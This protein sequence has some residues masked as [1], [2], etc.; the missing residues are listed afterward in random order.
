MDHVESGNRARLRADGDGECDPKHCG[1]S[2]TLWMVHRGLLEDGETIDTTCEEGLSFAWTEKCEPSF[3]L[4]KGKL[5]MSLEQVL[6]ELG[7]PDEGYCDAFHQ[8]LGCVLR[9]HR[10]PVADCWMSN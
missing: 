4:M 8:G 1:L 3:Q 2:G 7:E 6:T 9:Q 5:T 10:K